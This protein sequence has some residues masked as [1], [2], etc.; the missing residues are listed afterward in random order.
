[1]VKKSLYARSSD[2]QLDPGLVLDN[3]TLMLKSAWDVVGKP[4]YVTGG[5]FAHSMMLTF[6]Q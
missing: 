6:A 4:V 2:G 3:M 5:P 1:L